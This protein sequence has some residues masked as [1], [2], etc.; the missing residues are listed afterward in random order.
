MLFNLLGT[1]IV[2]IAAG[3]T[4]MLIHR[5]IGRKPASWLVPVAAGSAMLAFHIW[6]EYTWFERTTDALP[7][8]VVVTQSYSAQ[9]MLQPWTLLVPKINRF[10]ALD[11]GSIRRNDKAP[12]YVMADVFLVKRLD[13]TAKVTQIYDCRGGRRTEVDASTSVDEQGLPV[14]AAWTESDIDAPLFK[15]VCSSS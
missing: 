7:E 13:Q 10:T 1:F 11:R 9:T 2:G 3:G 6:N 4:V 14:D 15:M 12:D 5:I 8:D